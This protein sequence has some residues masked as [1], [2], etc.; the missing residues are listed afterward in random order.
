MSNSDPKPPL[1]RSNVSATAVPEDYYCVL[2]DMIDKAAGDPVQIRHIVYALAWHHFR[3]EAMLSPALPNA[4]SRARTVWALERALELE[5]AIERLE[6][7]AKH[8]LPEGVECDPGLALQRAV[9]GERQS[10]PQP[11][12]QAAAL[13]AHSELAGPASDFSEDSKSTYGQP[14]QLAARS[15]PE[16]QRS[17]NAV[18]V[19]REAPPAW[20]QRIETTARSPDWHDNEWQSRRTV[21]YGPLEKPTGTP[22]LVL[23]IQ[24]AGAAVL[25]VALFVGL[26]GWLYVGRPSAVNSG[27]MISAQS[28]DSLQ[29]SSGETGAPALNQPPAQPAL[30]F[31]L[32]KTYGIYAA[33]NGQLV[34]LQPLAVKTPDARIQLSAAITTPSKATLSDS[35]LAFVVFRRDL[36]NNAPQ[37]ASVR[38][39]ARVIR[40]TKFVDH[41]A[42]VSPV[43][44]SWRIRSKAFTFKVAPLEG[45]REMVVIRPP[46][47]FVFPAG[48][49]ALVLNGVGY[50]FTVA[51]PITASEQ[52]LEQME[53]LNGTV[54]SECRK[55]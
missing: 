21:E 37:T 46:P 51:G 7:D 13:L 50:D 53:A 49:Y 25:S 45:T 3:A 52:C 26:F 54:L 55:P 24:L 22:R 23:F 47:E 16:S 42:Q 6:A 11:P 2:R 9:Q 30:P 4:D 15:A 10:I 1:E 5:N 14:E 28:K 12:E 18:V 36:V 8:R 43:E 20:M 48:R 33:S 34:E 17:D 35:E 31:P 32:P 41:K 27:A 29:G 44:G 19:L 38:V 40:E 39:V